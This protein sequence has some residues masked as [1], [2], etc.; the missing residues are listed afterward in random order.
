MEVP[1]NY[2]FYNIEATIFCI[3]SVAIILFKQLTVF[4][5]DETQRAFTKILYIQLAYFVS[6]IIVVLVDI[7]ILPHTV[8]TVYAA[9]IL[10]FALYSYCSYC[11]FVYLALYQKSPYFI[12]YRSKHIYELPLIINLVIL[13]SSPLTGLYFSVNDELQFVSGYW[14][15]LIILINVCYPLSILI[16]SMWHNRKT[17]KNIPLTE[18]QITVA[19][20]LC[21]I[22]FGPL[23]SIQW[24]MPFLVYGLTLADLFVYVYY[25]DLLMHERNNALEAEKELAM[26]QSKAK[27]TFLSNM[28]HDIRTPMNAIIGFTNLAL[29]DPKDS[30]KVGEYLGKIQ[31]SSNH[32]LSLINDVLEMS[33]IES[34]KI[35][36]E[37]TNCSLPEI[38]HDLNT[39]IIG[40][41]ES[42]Q[43]ELHMDAMNVTHENIYCDKLRLNQVLLNLLSNAVKYTQSGGKISVRVTE[44]EGAPSGYASYAIS[45]KDNGMGM[46]PEFAA[47]VFEAF[48]REKNSTISGIQGTGLGMA[49]TKKIVELMHGTIEVKTELGKGTE[50][51]VRVNF[52]VQ[53]GSAVDLHITSPNEMHALVVDDDFNACDSITKMLHEMSLRAEWTLSGKEAV[54]RAKQSLERDDP[55]DVF[56]IDWKLRDLDGIEV[57]RQ[58]RNIVGNG[59]PILLMTAYDWPII[60]D[61][62]V[63]AGVNGFCNKPLFMS[64]LY[65]SLE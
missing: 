14:F 40:Q 49:I 4:N 1:V 22:I 51:I 52:K 7:Y 19:F 39:I 41:V 58:I 34:G 21:F 46:K 55:F 16:S 26:Q 11:V 43:Q 5:K 32:L 15:N 8:F 42:K 18:L 29:R 6:T 62:A 35:E 27:S 38:L 56:I 31:A 23:S 20:P 45:V 64:E 12:K 50:F 10:N 3:A 28:S 37:E 59:V 63:A 54:L 61:E 33:R 44:H 57:A 60:R 13:M 53:E 24:R 25:T 65:N 47:K 2:G 36:L 48:E 9:T 17:I 30:E